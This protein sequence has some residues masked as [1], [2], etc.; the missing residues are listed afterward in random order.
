MYSSPVS[1]TLVIVT[2]RDRNVCVACES[3]SAASA[4]LYRTR[5]LPP[6]VKVEVTPVAVNVGSSFFSVTVTVYVS[7]VLEVPSDM[8]M[9]HVWAPTLASVTRFA[10]A[11]SVAVCAAPP[12]SVRVIHVGQEPP[13]VLENVTSLASSSVAVRVTLRAESSTTELA[14]TAPAPSLLR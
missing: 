5:L 6:S 3:E 10:A 7:R 4:E 2:F 1:A 8:E 13:L 12:P 14:S 11:V 9:S